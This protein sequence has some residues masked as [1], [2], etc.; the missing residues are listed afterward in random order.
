[1]TTIGGQYF[2]SGIYT[3]FGEGYGLGVGATTPTAA[4]QRLATTT[5]TEN[6]TA[7]GFA[8]EQLNYKDKI[9]GTVAARIDENSAFGQ[10]QANTIYPSANLSYVMSDEGWFP[11][12]WFADRLRLRGSVGQ[13]GLPPGTT[14]AITFLSTLTYPSQGGE[15]PGLVLQQLGNLDLKP[16]VT[17]EYEAGFDLGMLKDRVNVEFTYYAKIAKNELFQ[18]PLP[19]SSGTGAGSQWVNLARVDNKGYEVSVEANILDTRPLSWDMRVSGSH[20]ANKLVDIGTVQLA[21]T[22]GARNVV[23]YPLFGLWDRPY[24]YKDAN[25]DGV[26]VPSEI[27]LAAADSFKGST[28]PAYEASMSNTVGLFRNRVHLSALMDYRGKFW[29]SYT[30]GSNRCVSAANCAAI[31]VAGSSLDDQ[32]AAVAAATGALR[33]TRWG[34]FQPNDFIKLREVSVAFDAPQSWINRYLHGRNA[35]LVLSG[36]NLAT[37]WTKYPGID[38]EANRQANGNDD[39]GTPPAIRYWLARLN[40]SF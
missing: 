15:S 6:A 30:I 33:N 7:G 34:I 2:K 40:F 19:P 8:Q 27:T 37:L 5:T 22:Q 28:L 26:I 18:Q 11:K 25:G 12:T 9:Y 20:V 31:N 36:R 10:H 39:L 24:T 21:Q 32:A 29:N 23:G 17:T 38:P 13:A 35:Q 16:E 1:M 4:Q 14:A 3:L